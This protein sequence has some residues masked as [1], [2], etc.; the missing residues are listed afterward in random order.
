MQFL[1]FF[2]YFEEKQKKNGK[3]FGTLHRIYY[4]CI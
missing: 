4:F 2:R 1:A 3:T